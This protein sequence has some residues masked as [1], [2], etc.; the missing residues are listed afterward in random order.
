MNRAPRN[1][2]LPILDELRARMRAE[3]LAR[4][5]ASRQA[6]PSRRPEPAAPTARVARRRGATLGRVTRRSAVI[7]A[8][9]CLLAGVALAAGIGLQGG[10]TPRSTSPELLGSVGGARVFGY[11]DGDRL[12]LRLEADGHGVGSCDMAPTLDGL[13]AVSSLVAGDRYV[14]GYADPAIRRLRAKVDG[15]KVVG[16]ASLPEDTEAATEAGIPTGLRWY[17]LDLGHV[18]RDPAHLRGLDPTGR[19]LGRGVL[20][21]SL[22]VIGRAC[23]LHYE[24]HALQRLR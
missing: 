16:R 20:D 3:I 1:P 21:C 9:L 23:R 12:C 4:E 15:R 6:R 11:R 8:L 5:V 19:P 18:G 10:N 14:L 7:V 13:S 2:D 22:A 24:R 17:L